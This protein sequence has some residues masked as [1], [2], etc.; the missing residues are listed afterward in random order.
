MPKSMK[1]L[2]TDFLVVE[3]HR[4][5]NINMVKAFAAMSETTV[6]SVNNYY[7]KNEEELRSLGVKVVDIS[8]SNPL[9]KMK[10]LKKW[11]I[12][13]N[14]VYT[15]RELK[16]GNYDMIVSLAF[17][18]YVNM[19]LPILF[20][21]KKIAVFYHKNIDEING[22]KKLLFSS[23]KNQIYHFVFEKSYKDYC[24][25]VL[26]ISPHRIYIVPHPSIEKSINNSKKGFFCVGLCH[27][28]DE[29]FIDG[30]ERLHKEFQENNITIL[31]R[32][33]RNRSNKT[34]VMFQNGFLDYCE[35]EKIV[36]ES[37]C[38]FVALP[39]SYIYRFSGTMY[40]SFSYHKKVLTTSLSHAKEYKDLY[41]GICEY[42]AS[43]LDLL[44]KL[45]TIRTDT[46]DS[47]TKFSDDHS[48]VA[49]GNVLSESLN[50]ILY[51]KQQE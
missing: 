2:I 40:E 11:W 4:M 44:S 19:F 29:T 14:M 8:N 31:L 21:N 42:V 23:Y 51:N 9:G 48:L 35:Y 16:H 28:N 36:A 34:N 32:T 33:K 26:K 38:V 46:N 37:S 6:L 10:I 30:V 17:D 5:F 25:N 27:Q 24:V 12:L 15:T 39:Q 7:L 13:K 18:T 43:P 3:A 22:I 20:H 41:P 45:M 1:I 47:F 49:I 50:E